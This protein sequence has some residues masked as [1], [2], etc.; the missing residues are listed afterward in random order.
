VNITA[1]LLEIKSRSNPVGGDWPQS[2]LLIRRLNRE[3]KLVLDQSAQIPAPFTRPA[4][5]QALQLTKNVETLLALGLSEEAA[6]L[7]DRTLE[8]MERVQ[9]S[10]A[11]SAKAVGSGRI[12]DRWRLDTAATLENSHSGN[13]ATARIL[14]LSRSGMQI[15][16]GQPLALKSLIRIET[17]HSLY[18]AD[19]IYC[20]ADGAQFVA[21][22]RLNER[23]P[24][25][26]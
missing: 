1:N 22:L 7:I 12:S 15:E 9:G 20:I 25:P 8:L 11:V 10:A 18:F 3:L 19:V 16:T 24:K 23:H 14:N 17:A 2:R 21:G 13:A 26:V 5:E 4:L 6:V